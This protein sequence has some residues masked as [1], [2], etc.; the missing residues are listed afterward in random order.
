MASSTSDTKTQVISTYHDHA[1]FSCAQ[2]SAVVA[3]QD[4]LI[5]KSFS[6]REGRGYL[7]HSA[8]NVKLGKKEDRPLLTGVHTVADVFCVGC[9]D[10]LG[11]YYHKA[12]DYSQKYKEG[13]YLLER[14][15][16]VK[17]NAWKLDE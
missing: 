16:L 5:S 3:L 14:E 12:S 11:W 6:G 7:M 13:K 1:T 10:R 2:C 15:K 17:D 9:N 8:V 4:E